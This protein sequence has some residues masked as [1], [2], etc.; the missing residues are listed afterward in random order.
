VA[1]RADAA[2]VILGASHAAKEL[3]GEVAAPGSSLV[4]LLADPQDREAVEEFLA[5]DAPALAQALHL[6]RPEEEPLRVVCTLWRCQGEVGLVGT[7]PGMLL[8]D[9]R[10]LVQAEKLAGVGRMAAQVAHQLNTPLGA[11][12][13]SAQALEPELDGTDYATDVAILIEETRRCQRTVRRLQNFSRSPGIEDEMVN[14]CH[15]FHRVFQIL[16]HSLEAAGVTLRFVIARGRYLVQGDP[17]E[18]EHAIFALVENAMAA[19]PRGGEVRVAMRLDY[20][21]GHMLF[22]VEDD[23]EGLPEEDLGRIFEPFYTTKPEG[24][25]TGLGLA[26][27]RRI[28]RDHQGELTAGHAK[29][30]GAAFEIRLPLS[31]KLI[32]AYADDPKRVEVQAIPFA[33]LQARARGEY[34]A[35]CEVTGVTA[36]RVRG[37]AR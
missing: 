14:F 23:G 35:G 13:L 16:G 28:V 4:D 25:G 37:G 10:R 7:D 17:S 33:T 20:Q 12:L 3:L 24:S 11:I 31:P 29:T 5:T 2:G 9:T 26:I 34:G 21:A 1:L 6:R 32:E 15:L 27:A 18:L 36:P 30:G 22:R 19:S 8:G